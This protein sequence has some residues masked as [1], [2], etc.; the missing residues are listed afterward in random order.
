MREARQTLLIFIVHPILR[1]IFEALA[2]QH[3]D[4]RPRGFTVSRQWTN[5][6]MKV[7]MNWTIRKGITATS[8][9]PLDWME[10]ELNMNYR[11]AYIVK[12]FGIPSSLVV[13][14]DQTGIHLV[15]IAGDK[16]WDAKSTK[17]VK[18]LG[19]EDKKTNHMCYVV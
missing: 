8:K 1:G 11:V 3:L 10:Q 9:L 15:P 2:P 17:D 19:I 6:F 12:V 7:Y 14:S 13:N 4:D 5:E 16:I 18:I